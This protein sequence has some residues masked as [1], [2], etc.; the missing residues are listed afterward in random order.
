MP[1][2]KYVFVVFVSWACVFVA[3]GCSALS[4]AGGGARCDFESDPLE[5]GWHGVRKNYQPFEGGVT[6]APDRAGD[7]CLLIRKGGWESPPIRTLADGLYRLS[8]DARTEEPGFWRVFFYDGA[9][10]EHHADNYSRLYATGEEWK[11]QE[12]FFEVREGT[13]FMKAGFDPLSEEPLYLDDIELRPA[14][15]EEALAWIDRV[16]DDI[17]EPDYAPPVDR[18]ELLPR[19]RET[20]RN[21]G[22]LRIAMLGD[23]IA[24]D[25][26]NSLFHLRLERVYPGTEV[27]L[28]RSVRSGT[29]CTY[30]REEDRVQEYV[31]QYDPDL[32]I[33]GGI[34]HGHNAGAIREVIRKVREQSDPEILVLSGAISQFV[35]HHVWRKGKRILVTREEL[36]EKNRKFREDLAAMCEKEDVAYMDIRGTWAEYLESAEKDGDWFR[37]DPTHGNSRGKQAVGEMLVRFLSPAGEGL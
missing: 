32:L 11:S 22:K 24:N 30:Y 35:T 5:R 12:C 26:A 16:R 25:T 2:L 27:H 8:F 28:I 14:D 9:G 31:L 34:S 29:G 19:T 37:R 20:L 21:G 10:R 15:P 7:R 6:D 1:E 36:L 17:P 33:I 3:G 13:E 4:A 18:W 23:S